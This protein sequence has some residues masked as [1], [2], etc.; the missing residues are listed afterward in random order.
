MAAQGHSYKG[1]VHT[2][3]TAEENR[4]CVAGAMD[5]TEG[6]SKSKSLTVRV[7]NYLR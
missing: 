3:E 1:I 4:V 6:L 2:R 5:R 7:Q